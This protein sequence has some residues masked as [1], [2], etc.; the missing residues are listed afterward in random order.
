MRRNH[1]NDT[2]IKRLDVF[3]V[4]DL[5]LVEV[6][7]RVVMTLGR[8]PEWSFWIHLDVDVLD[9]SVMPAVDCPG[10][11]GIDEGDLARLLHALVKDQ[12]CAG[13]TVTVFDPDLDPDGAYAAR[14][15]ALLSKVLGPDGRGTLG[16][17][18]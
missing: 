16:S 11:P 1:I 10:S 18:T 8:Q 14:L 15:V 4:R 2:A 9:Q 3:A 13:M 5:G 12:R 7:S 6:I 17:R